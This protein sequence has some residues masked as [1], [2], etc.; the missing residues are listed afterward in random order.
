MAESPAIPMALFLL[1]TK[2]ELYVSSAVRAADESEDT[3]FSSDMDFASAAWALFL[4][5]LPPAAAWAAS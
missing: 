1:F 3:D 4:T 5:T 2:S